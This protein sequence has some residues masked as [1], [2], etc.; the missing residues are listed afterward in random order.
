MELEVLSDDA[1]AARR[2]ADLLVEALEAGLGA[3][4]RAT[5][6]VSGGSSPGPLFAD[7]FAR[8]LAWQHVTVFQV[9]ERVTEDPRH[10]NLTLLEQAVRE[11]S[12]TSVSVVP[13][14]VGG[15]LDRELGLYH[16]A[17]RLAAGDPP[18]LDAVHLGI[19]PD[20][21]TAS[22]PPGH[23]VL[24]EREHDLARIEEFNG[25]ERLTLTPP[26]VDRARRVVFFVP[27]E[28]AAEALAR[29]CAGDEI[30]AARAPAGSI[31]V[32]TAAA[33]ARVG[34]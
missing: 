14:T 31:V 30:P 20:G 19:G 27:G 8:D 6:A 11:S 15:D 23:P 22:W 5:L 16:Q 4:G 25:F 26:I 29:L 2:T 12:A 28:E 9:D 7:L 34:T 33:A 32:A 18:V 13:F 3:R 24:R 21:H 10:R 1:A 17:L